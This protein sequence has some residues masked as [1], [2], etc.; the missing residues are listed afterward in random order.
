MEITYSNHSFRVK[1]IPVISVMTMTLDN[2]GDESYPD[3][4]VRRVHTATT[5]NDIHN[6]ILFSVCMC[7]LCVCMC[8]C[9]C[10]CMCML[11][12]RGV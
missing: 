6:I 9:M 2:D 1:M 8:I 7:I 5:V 4:V 10:M 3:D 12:R 11:L